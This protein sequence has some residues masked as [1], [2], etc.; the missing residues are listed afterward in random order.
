M[1]YYGIYI[2]NDCKNL[3]YVSECIKK[4]YGNVHSV[5]AHSNELVELEIL[6]KHECS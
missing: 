3:F 5:T 6:E 4:F 1:Y 2:A